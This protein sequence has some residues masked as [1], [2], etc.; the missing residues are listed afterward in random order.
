MGRY[1]K[2]TD[3]CAGDEVKGNEDLFGITSKCKLVKCLEFYS[4]IDVENRQFWR[5]DEKIWLS[6]QAKADLS[7][8][9]ENLERYNGRPAWRP[10][11]I[12]SLFVDASTTGWCVKLDNLTAFGNW[13][14]SSNFREI[15]KLEAEA[16]LLGLK[17]FAE[18]LRGF[19]VLIFVDNYIW[20][21][22]IKWVPSEE[23]PADSWTRTFDSSDW[24][25][26]EEIFQEIYVTF[27]PHSIDQMASHLNTKLQSTEGTLSC[28]KLQGKSNASSSRMAI[29]R[30]VAPASEVK[31]EGFGLARTKSNICA[32][33]IRI[34]RTMEKSK[35]KILGGAHLAVRSLSQ[36]A[37]ELAKDSVSPFYKART[38]KYWALY[39]KFCKRFSINVANPQEDSIL[40]FIMWLDIIGISSQTSQILQTVISNLHFEGKKD[41][42]KSLAVTKVLRA[43]KKEVSRNKTP[44]DY[45]PS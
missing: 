2:G 23:N 33:P 14:E 8:L 35:V 34:C 32:G 29:S 12:R 7:W 36:R 15:A 13:V 26:K 45:I 6:D 39:N 4:L 38:E 1:R 10:S 5:W 17:G 25:I 43:I 22:E 37:R 11:L 40:A 21:Y 44:S 41:F 31:L 19:W 9:L 24:Y 30:M 42:R 28:E 3:S 20:V 16:V 18:L 27:G